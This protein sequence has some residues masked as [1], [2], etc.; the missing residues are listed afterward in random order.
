MKEITI[1]RK[2][3]TMTKTNKKIINIAPKAEH[4]SVYVFHNILFNF[5]VF[6]NAENANEAYD[7]FDQCGMAHREQWKIMVELSEQPSGGPNG[8]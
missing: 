1:N 8:S 3:N 6:I 4:D 7:R 5:D 2:K